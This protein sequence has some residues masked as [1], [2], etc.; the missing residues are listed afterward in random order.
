MA[1]RAGEEAPFLTGLVGET[2]VVLS[3]LVIV[4]HAD[5]IA[6]RHAGDRADKHH[7]AGAVARLDAAAV[8]RLQVGNEV[9]DR[10][11]HDGLAFFLVRH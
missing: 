8:A 1:W 6:T 11:H 9:V 2:A 7:L 3:H 4:L 10:V 5:P